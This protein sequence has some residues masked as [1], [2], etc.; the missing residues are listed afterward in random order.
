M[1]T[2]CI[3]SFPGSNRSNC[4]AQVTL[5][6]CFGHPP[7]PYPIY[8]KLSSVP[9]LLIPSKFGTYIHNNSPYIRGVSQKQ[10]SKTNAPVDFPHVTPKAD[11]E[12]RQ[13][14]CILGNRIPR[15]TVALTVRPVPKVPSLLL[16]LA[17]VGDPLTTLTHRSWSRRRRSSHRR[18][19]WSV[20]A[21]PQA[22]TVGYSAV[23]HLAGGT[24][25]SDCFGSYQD[26][27]ARPIPPWN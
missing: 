22:I 25:L 4:T 16:I 23:T 5:I 24:S 12:Q 17:G 1:I 26:V 10:I 7:A 14:L 13:S 21:V 20:W 15:V 27:T 8:K 18:R 19:T 3:V 6:K 2:K 9:T 11:V